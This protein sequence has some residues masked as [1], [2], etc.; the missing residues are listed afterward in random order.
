MSPNN[1]IARLREVSKQGNQ[2]NFQEYSKYLES[3]VDLFK[4][5]ER[6]S[7]VFFD[8]KTIIKNKFGNKVKVDARM[9]I[10]TI[11]KTLGN[12]KPNYAPFKPAVD[13]QNEVLRVVALAC[14][15]D[16]CKDEINTYTKLNKHLQAE[17]TKLQLE[18]DPG[19]KYNI[20]LLTD[21]P[22]A[23]ENARLAN[24]LI[25]DQRDLLKLKADEFISVIVNNWKITNKIKIISK[26]LPELDIVLTFLSDGFSKLARMYLK[27]DFDKQL[28]LYTE[29]ANNPANQ[30]LMHN[31]VC[32]LNDDYSNISA[33]S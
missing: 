14:N 22:T 10:A 11:L 8:E 12:Q 17:F 6:Y 29:Y 20:P 15:N 5:I 7:S 33:K 28:Q 16:D 21:F 2:F 1:I 4:L 26:S 24:K 18:Q 3:V 19:D 23:T 31:F 9:L 25:N 32:V 27:Q 30:K 13:F